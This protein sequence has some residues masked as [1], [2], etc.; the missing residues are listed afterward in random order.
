M[1]KRRATETFGSAIDDKADFDGLE[2][3]NSHFS[4]VSMVRSATDGVL[5]LGGVA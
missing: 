1:V 5:G 2:L 3:Q 4:L